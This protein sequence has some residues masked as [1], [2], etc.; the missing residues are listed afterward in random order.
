MLGLL[1][2]NYGLCV[3]ALKPTLEWPI[4]RLCQSIRLRKDNRDILL[5]RFYNPYQ[6]IVLINETTTLRKN[7]PQQYNPRTQQS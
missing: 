2:L 1:R 6:P 5:K 3:H 7:H 4:H